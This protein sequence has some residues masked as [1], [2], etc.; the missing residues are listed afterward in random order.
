[1]DQVCAVL[2]DPQRKAAMR[3]TARRTAIETYDLAT[4]CLPGQLQLIQKLVSG[5]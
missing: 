5:R 4:V 1:M 2:D 3:A